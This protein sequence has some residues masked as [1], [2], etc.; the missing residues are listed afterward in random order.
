MRKV[1]CKIKELLIFIYTHMLCTTWEEILLKYSQRQNLR[2]KA[3]IF[4]SMVYFI[5]YAWYVKAS[6]CFASFFF[7]L[8]FS[9]ASLLVSHNFFYSSTSIKH[10]WKKFPQNEQQ[11][12][13]KKKY[14]FSVERKFSIFRKLLDS[15]KKIKKKNRYLWN[16]L[17][18]VIFHKIIIIIIICRCIIRWHS[19]TDIPNNAAVSIA[20]NNFSLLQWHIKLKAF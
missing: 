18:K 12:Q 9:S 3:N 13:P 15:I 16:F 2:Q 19:K 17:C 14:F 11:Q 4:H 10:W 6:L 20:L 1:S 8:F 7:F 5:I